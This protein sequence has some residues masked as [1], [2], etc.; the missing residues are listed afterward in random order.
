[1]VTF[2]RAHIRPSAD[3]SAETLRAWRKWDD[4]LKVLKYEKCQPIILHSA[5]LFFRYEGEKKSFLEF[6]TTK[7]AL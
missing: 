5:E 3:F 7:R 6:I 2:K 1:M 4:I